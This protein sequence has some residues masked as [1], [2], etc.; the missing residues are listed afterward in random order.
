MAGQISIREGPTYEEDLK[1]LDLTDEDREAIR[2]ATAEILAAITESPNYPINHAPAIHFRATITKV[3]KSVSDCR[4][5]TLASAVRC[6][7]RI[8]GG[9]KRCRSFY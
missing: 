1:K 7:W 4:G 3:G 6:A 5:R 8:G 2:A 9:E